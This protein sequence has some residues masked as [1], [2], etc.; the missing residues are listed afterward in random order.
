VPREVQESLTIGR[1]VHRWLEGWWLGHH[2]RMPL[3]SSAVGRACCLGYLAR[4]GAGP[5]DAYE[6]IRPELPWEE[7]IGGVRC[8]GTIDVRCAE[9]G[10]EQ[11]IVE[12]KT[13]SSEIAPGSSYWREVMTSN[14]QVSMYLAA[15]PRA[16]VLY[17]VIRKPALRHLEA[18]SKRR[19]RETD[20]ELVARM[21]A[22]MAEDPGKYFQR[23]TVVRIESEADAFYQDLRLV[24]ERRRLPLQPR[25]PDACFTYGRRCGYFPVCWEGHSL[26]DETVFQEQEDG[27]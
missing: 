27:R 18:N 8:A 22:A 12:H 15:F 4:Y 1:E 11:V 5:G 25:N 19:E 17:D 26:A 2:E 13:T 3:P 10:G 6:W 20:D 21:L 14:V 23:A 24:D 16:K 7:T 9:R